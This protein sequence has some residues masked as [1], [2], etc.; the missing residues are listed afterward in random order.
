[1]DSNE[2][3]FVLGVAPILEAG[4]G[5]WGYGGAPVSIYLSVGYNS[6]E[7]A[8][9]VDIMSGSEKF[10]S[11]LSFFVTAGLNVQMGF[12][13]SANGLAEVHS[14]RKGKTFYPP[15]APAYIKVSE[16]GDYASSGFST[17][18]PPVGADFFTWQNAQTM[19]SMLRLRFSNLYPG[20]LRFTWGGLPSPKAEMQKVSD[21]LRQIK[22][23][24]QSKLF[25]FQLSPSRCR[26]VLREV[27]SDVQ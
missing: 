17:T 15:A 13:L 16:R 2:S 4:A 24:T 12:Y 27:Y 14:A 7:K 25:N 22:S 5:K 3:G 19:T 10:D 6:A 11:S 26:P 18:L 8:V 1:V 21:F 23:Y 20:F 9:V